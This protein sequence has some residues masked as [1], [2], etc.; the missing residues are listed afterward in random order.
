MSINISPD[1][2][3]LYVD[4][5]PFILSEPF[6]SKTAKYDFKLGLRLGLKPPIQKTKKQPSNVM[7]R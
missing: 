1:G 3:N 7:A 4:G 5:Y 6:N 2:K